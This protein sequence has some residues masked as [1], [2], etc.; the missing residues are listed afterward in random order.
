MKTLNL[1]LYGV[2]EDGEEEQDLEKARK[3]A[4]EAL[5]NVEELG[6]N[7]RN[8]YSPKG[9]Q[10][11]EGLRRRRRRAADGDDNEDEGEEVEAKTI[12]EVSRNQVQPVF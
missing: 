9:R 12:D 1:G 10:E 2:N 5:E 11:S 6:K 8:I 3:R 4:G 7:V